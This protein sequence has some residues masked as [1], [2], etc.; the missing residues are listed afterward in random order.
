MTDESKQHEV[1]LTDHVGI[2]DD[3]QVSV[4]LTA[5]GVVTSGTTTAWAYQ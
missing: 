4:T 3:L 5:E 1:Q 2:T